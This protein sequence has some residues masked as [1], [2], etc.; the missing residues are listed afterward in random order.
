MLGRNW[1]V[2]LI[3]PRPSFPP[4]F[5]SE[6]IEP[7]Q[8]AML[9]KL[10]LM[11]TLLPR[12]RRIREIKSYYRG[13]LFKVTPTEQYGLYY[14]VLVNT[15]REAL[16]SKVQVKLGRATQV[17]A[18]TER[19]SVTLDG[20]EQLTGRLVVLACGLNADLLAGLRLNRVWI[21]KPQSAAFAFT[22]ARPTGEPFPFDAVTYT[23]RSTETGIDYVSFF[24]IEQTLRANLFAYPAADRS[25]FQR[26]AR[27]WEREL[28]RILPKLTRA[29]GDHRI[30]GRVEA[31]MINLYRTDG[32]P[33][34]GVVLIGDAWQNVCPATGMGLTKIFS[35]VEVLSEC[36]AHWFETPGIGREKL[37]TFFHD[38]RKTAVDA[39]ALRNAHYRRSACSARSLKWKIHRLR[40]SFE[41]ARQEAGL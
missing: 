39:K 27:N 26:F 1:R 41:I 2:T 25:W 16:P 31:S 36:V 35:D 6:K 38:P 24:P 28:P 14:S 5:K 34:P 8:A 37:E 21:E 32:E 17:T 40:L 15:L 19:P 4:V 3:D 12:A 11:Q 10:G 7:H 9:H 18:S 13:R 30:T 20:G 33:A 29:I 22:L 23:E